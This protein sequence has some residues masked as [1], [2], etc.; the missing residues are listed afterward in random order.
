MHGI[1]HP[2]PHLHASRLPPVIAPLIVRTTAVE[3]RDS[4]RSSAAFVSAAI[5]EEL[6]ERTAD[7]LLPCE[8]AAKKVRIC[9]ARLFSPKQPKWFPLCCIAGLQLSK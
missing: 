3:G 7:L 1:Q 6:R 4:T 9:L 2:P 5:G 8:A